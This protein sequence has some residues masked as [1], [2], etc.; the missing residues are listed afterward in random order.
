MRRQSRAWSSPMSRC[1]AI[2]TGRAAT[3]AVAQEMMGGLRRELGALAGAAAADVPL[4]YGGSV[5]PDNIASFAAEADVDGALVGGG[6][7]CAPTSSSPSPP[8]SPRR[9]AGVLTARR[10]V[11]RRSSRPSCSSP[12]PTASGKT[13]A[14]LLLAERLPIEVINA[15]SPPGS[16]AICPSARPSRRRSSAPC[17]PTT[18]STSPTLASASTS[19]RT[20][21][22]PAGAID[23]GARTRPPARR[24]WWGGAVRLGACGGLASAARSPSAGGAGAP[25]AS[26]ARGRRRGA[27]RRAAPRRSRVRRGHRP[28]QRAARR[29]R[30]GSL[31]RH[32]AALLRAALSRRSRRSR[33]A[34][35]G[36][37]APAPSCAAAWMRASTG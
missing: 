14:A 23:G 37:G 9:G 2:G 33:R 24:R 20:S 5:N 28:A 16:T 17:A 21:T 18:S 13:N 6:R 27:P 10:W 35:P 25:R 8:P 15:D 32:R 26:G 36:Y 29:P 1:G 19:P 4:L 22:W 3:P 34:S 12:G 30:F 7:A 31:P 11:H